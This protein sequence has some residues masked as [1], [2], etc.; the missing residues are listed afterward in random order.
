[1]GGK[2]GGGIGGRGGDP[3]EQAEDGDRD[4]GRGI[5]LEERRGKRKERG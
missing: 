4:S 5:E 2:E 3:G 1:M